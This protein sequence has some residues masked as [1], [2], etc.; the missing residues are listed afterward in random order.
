[1][2]E[3]AVNSKPWF[4][5]AKFIEAAE[6]LKTER[7]KLPADA[8]IEEDEQLFP[9]ICLSRLNRVRNVQEVAAAPRGRRRINRINR[10]RRCGNCNQEG[11]SRSKCR[12]NSVWFDWFSKILTDTK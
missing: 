9:P 10:V 1:M 2:R 5:A 11:H 8:N 6:V 12:F 7:M 4:L 3:W